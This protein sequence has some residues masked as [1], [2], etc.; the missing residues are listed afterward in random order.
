MDALGP[1][2]P[3]ELRPHEELPRETVCPRVGA[4]RTL[5]AHP[6]VCRCWHRVT[7][8]TH[9]GR[10]TQSVR[11]PVGLRGDGPGGAARHC[12]QRMLLSFTSYFFSQTLKTT[13]IDLYYCSAVSEKTK[14]PI[15][16]L[17]MPSVCVWLCGLQGEGSK[18]VH[19][20][21]NLI[22]CPLV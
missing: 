10:H 19:V 12:A 22:M 16:F 4:R 1:K 7:G 15:W 8:R 14:C 11:L 13:C 5:R 17:K 3:A 6:A 9:L 21:E 20:L 18:R 2:S